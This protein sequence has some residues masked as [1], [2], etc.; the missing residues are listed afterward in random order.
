MFSNNLLW[1][2]SL[3]KTVRIWDG[4]SGKCRHVINGNNGDGGHVDRI[5]TVK[6][7]LF[8]GKAYVA[9]SSTDKMVKIWDEQGQCLSTTDNDARVFSIGL[10]TDSVNSSN[11]TLLLCGLENGRILVRALPNMA[12]LATFDPNLTVGHQGAVMSITTGPQNTFF[13]GGSEGK[14]LAWA[15]EPK[16]WA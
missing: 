2:A 9:T 7:F 15:L 12:L 4:A 3:D 8:E 16:I 1:T 11:K 5:C 10:I 6:T 14:L 13:T